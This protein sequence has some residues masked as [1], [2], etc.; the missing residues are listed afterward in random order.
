MSNSIIKFHLEKNSKVKFCLLKKYVFANFLLLD[1]Q[2][3][4][5]SQKWKYDIEYA[6]RNNRYTL[7]HTENC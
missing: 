1:K 4:V 7:L 2:N 5:F 6:K 3:I